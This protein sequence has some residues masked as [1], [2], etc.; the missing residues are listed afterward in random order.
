[1]FGIATKLVNKLRNNLNFGLFVLLSLEIGWCLDALKGN[2]PI[3]IQ[4]F[5]WISGLLCS[6]TWCKIDLEDGLRS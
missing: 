1:M 2:R 6:L 3:S 5:S 4:V